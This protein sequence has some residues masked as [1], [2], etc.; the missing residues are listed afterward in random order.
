MSGFAALLSLETEAESAA[1]RRSEEQGSDHWEKGGMAFELHDLDPD[2]TLDVACQGGWKPWGTIG[3]EECRNLELGHEVFG[4]G[5]GA[6]GP[7]YDSA[8][9]R[10]G[11][12]AAAAGCVAL[13]PG[14]GADAPDYIVEEGALMPE[15][16][17]ATALTAKGAFSHLVRFQPASGAASLPMTALMDTVLAAA[18][19]TAA[20]YVALAEVE[21]LVG[22]STLRSPALST[23]PGTGSFPEVRDWVAFCGERVHAGAL[24][25]IVGFV[26]ASGTGRAIHG[27]P[28]L[29]SR[30][31]WRAHAHAVV[32]PFRPL[33]KGRIDMEQTVRQLFGAADPVA[34]LHLVEDDRQAVGLGQ[35]ALVRGACWCSPAH[36]SEERK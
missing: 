7:D 36:F 18:G 11:D 25:M 26:D 20:A 8:R 22:M 9:E 12:Y 16:L 10:M 33:P 1:P 30:A 15:I 24:A 13:L 4:I 2:A 17:A 21:G 28:V 35:S 19:T 34:L 14:T 27:L 23:G 6:P 31:P 3:P 32:F 5:T 29:P